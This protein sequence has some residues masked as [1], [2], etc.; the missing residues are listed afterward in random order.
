MSTRSMLSRNGLVEVRRSH[1]KQHQRTFDSRIS[2][3]WITF[4]SVT[5]AATILHT[6]EVN[7]ARDSHYSTATN[8]VNRLNM[9]LA[10]CRCK[11]M[12]NR[13]VLVV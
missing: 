13:Y 6:E 2:R 7:V 11:V 5:P 12:N 9:N 4:T 1:S 8:V 3:L 10:L